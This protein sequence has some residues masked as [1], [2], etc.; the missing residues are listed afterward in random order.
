MSIKFKINMI[1]TLKDVKVII[2]L[3]WQSV[4][5]FDS[6]INNHKIPC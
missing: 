5:N 6:G 3:A 1:M 4:D 2:I